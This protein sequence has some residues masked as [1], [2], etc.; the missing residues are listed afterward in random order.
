FALGVA[1][2]SGREE[3]R[4]RDLGFGEAGSYNHY[5]G[6]HFIV[7]TTAFSSLGHRTSSPRL[8]LGLTAIVRTTHNQEG[9]N[10]AKGPAGSSFSGEFVRREWGADA[11]AAPACGN[12][13][14]QRGYGAQ[15]GNGKRCLPAGCGAYDSAGRNSDQ[16]GAGF[17]GTGAGGGT[18]DSWEDDGAGVRV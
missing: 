9:C 17:R 13:A 18:S 12:A 1:P 6:L 16:S 15:A 3:N 4:R 7:N 14:E 8:N 10:G 5:P 11:E 2:D